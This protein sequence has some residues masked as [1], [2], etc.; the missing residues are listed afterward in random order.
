MPRPFGVCAVSLVNKSELS[1][2]VSPDAV[3]LDDVALKKR[4]QKHHKLKKRH[5]LSNDSGND[6]VLAGEG[7]FLC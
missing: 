7:K 3:H 5:R 4:H 1:P 2:S 6:S